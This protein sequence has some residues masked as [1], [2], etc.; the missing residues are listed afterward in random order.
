MSVLHLLK[1]HCANGLILF[2]YSLAATGKQPSLL[3]L[4]AKWYPDEYPP[5]WFTGSSV[6]GTY[7]LSNLNPCQQCGD[8]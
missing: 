5:H 4:P 2:L 6:M 3:L 1:W 8:E 7:A